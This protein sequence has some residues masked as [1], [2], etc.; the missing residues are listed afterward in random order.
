MSRSALRIGIAIPQTYD[1]PLAPMLAIARFVRRAEDLQ[2]DSLWVQEQ[3][4]GASPMLEPLTLLAY[5]ASMTA[6]ARLGVAV[7]LSGLREPVGLARTLATLDQLSSGRLELGVGLGD[8]LLGDAVGVRSGPAAARFAD[9][10]AVMEALWERGR[11]THRSRFVDL[12]DWAS[13]PLPVQRPRPPLWFG[14]HDRRALARAVAMGDGWIGAGSA[15]HEQ[16]VAQV[17]VVREA[18]ARAG[19]APE[20]FSLGKRLYVALTNQPLPASDRL[21]SWFGRIYGDAELADRVAVVGD[22]TEIA[23]H[24]ERLIALGTRLL[25]LNPVFE[26]LAQAERLAAEVIPRL[27]PLPAET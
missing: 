4:R 12:D 21:R 8:P 25:I 5:V 10:L 15:S 7:L 27:R 19:R 14:G 17:R 23:A 6:R 16:Y 20:T 1:G 24:L 2:F 11:V 22:P 26:E 13:A 18:L 3:V 9:G